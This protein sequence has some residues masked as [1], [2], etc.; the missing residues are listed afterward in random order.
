MPKVKSGRLRGL[1]GMK[2]QSSAD[3]FAWADRLEAQILDPKNPDD[4]RWLK[5]WAGKIRQLA[6]QKLRSLEIKER[7]R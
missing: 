3:L 1:D 6:E 2:P 4:P 5:R 7:S